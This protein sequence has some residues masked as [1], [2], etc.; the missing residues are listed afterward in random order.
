MIGPVPKAHRIV[1][2]PTGPPSNHPVSVAR[3]RSVML[4]SPMGTRLKRLDSPTSRV[5]L[6]PQPRDAIIYVY[7]V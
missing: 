3:L 1:P 5:S 7:W 4:T 6:G 2:G